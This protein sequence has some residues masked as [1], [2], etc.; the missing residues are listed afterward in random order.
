MAEDTTLSPV[1][2]KRVAQRALVLQ[3]YI[4]RRAWGVLYATLSLAIFLTVFVS[5]SEPIIALRFAVDMAASGTALIVILWAFKRARETTE[6]SNAMAHK[7][8]S[9]PLGYRALVPTWAAIY[10]VLITTVIFF[11]QQAVLAILVV[12]LVLAAY[13]YYALRLSFPLR[14][15]PE[16]IAALSSLA[17]AAGGSLALLPFLS[18]DPA[19]Y[20]I[21]WGSMMAVW[22]FAAA[23]ARTRP[24]PGSRESW[25]T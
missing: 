16:G 22:L 15:P 11:R 9:R 4:L 17:V 24:L 14:L 20:V 10:A 6:V 19:P 1:E 13:V 5:P 2:I 7:R 21:L 8:W 12:Y 23:Y 3:S 18:G 25:E